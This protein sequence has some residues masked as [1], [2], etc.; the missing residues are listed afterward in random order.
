MVQLLERLEA[1]SLVYFPTS[2]ISTTNGAGAAVSA[3]FVFDPRVRS[4]LAA[5]RGSSVSRNFA[6]VLST[7]IGV[8]GMV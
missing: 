6:A 4:E 3:R 7:W 8:G 5:Q 2:V 1:I